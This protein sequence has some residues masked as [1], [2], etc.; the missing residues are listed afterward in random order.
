V[1]PTGSTKRRRVH[2]TKAQGVK[3][4]KDKEVKG[5]GGGCELGERKKDKEIKGPQKREEE[6]RTPRD[7]RG[8]HTLS[9][10]K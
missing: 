10:E 2:K 7:L 8:G 1:N 9:G 4:K 6:T 3:G 5:G